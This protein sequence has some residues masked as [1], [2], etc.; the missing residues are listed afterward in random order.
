MAADA[1]PD[2]DALIERLTRA[3][4]RFDFV[5]ALSLLELVTPEATPPGEAGPLE[6][7]SLRL[8]SHGGMGFPP[9][10]LHAIAHR[11]RPRE[12]F[13]V[14]LNF[15][16]LTGAS[17]PLPNYFQ[18]PIVHQQEGGAALRD[19]LAIFEH[20]IYS[21]FWRAWKKF[22][23][24]L[25]VD[26]VADERRARFLVGIAG[27]SLPVLREGGAVEPLRFASFAGLLSAVRPTAAG[28]TNLVSGYFGGLPVR[29]LEFVPRRVVIRDR[30]VLGGDGGA[31]S[32]RLDH[33]AI[34]GDTVVDRVSLVRVVIGPLSLEWFLQLLPG[35]ERSRA[36]AGVV[37][38]YLPPQFEY[39]VQLVLRHEEVPPCRLGAP[40]TRLGWLSWLGQPAQDG[41]S[42]PMSASVFAAA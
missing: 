21:L 38:L 24:D 31:R 35:G 26:R 40:H 15:L 9:A 17:S 18:D 33:S 14:E 1:G 3:A 28:L 22:R 13:E 42:S 36:L 7:E 16:G 34:L 30:A 11:R 25:A 10:D 37:R 5:Q 12:R 4:S 27:Y 39:Q 2:R 29:V 19:F 20:R 41:E 23:I 6:S 32:A 8:R